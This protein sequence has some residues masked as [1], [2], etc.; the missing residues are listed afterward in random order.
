MGYV[1]KLN[2]VVVIK[3]IIKRINVFKHIVYWAHCCSNDGLGAGISWDSSRILAE[4]VNRAN[5]N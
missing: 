5:Q 3:V 4:I 2:T 1:V